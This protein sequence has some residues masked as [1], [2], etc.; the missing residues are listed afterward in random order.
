MENRPVKLATGTF[1]IIIAT[2]TDLPI[3]LKIPMLLVAC[4]SFIV[5]GYRY[6]RDRKAPLATRRLH[7]TKA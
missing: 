3:Y 7:K 6:Y 4:I 2:V 5:S 1:L